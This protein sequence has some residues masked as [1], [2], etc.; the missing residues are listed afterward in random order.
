M[1]E[2]ARSNETMS[3]SFKHSPVAKLKNNQHYKRLSNKR[4]RI[5]NELSNRNAYKKNHLTW[6]ICDYKTPPRS[7]R[8]YMKNPHADPTDEEINEYEKWYKRK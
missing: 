3:R 5:N 8:E 7:L 2:T 6:D 4:T 1:R